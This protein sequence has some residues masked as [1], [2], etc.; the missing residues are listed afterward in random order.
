VERRE[1]D[2]DLQKLAEAGAG[3]FGPTITTK[4]EC[5]CL[6]SC[7]TISYNADF[8]MVDIDLKKFLEASEA[9][10]HQNIEKE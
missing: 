9:K 2:E 6:P 10:E 5:D 4:T 3:S 7:V 8:A 1:I